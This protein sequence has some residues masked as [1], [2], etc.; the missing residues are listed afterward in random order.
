M[1]TGTSRLR[2]GKTE[3]GK[4]EPKYVNGAG[5]GNHARSRTK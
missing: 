2:N 1:E 3:I 4:G 5:K